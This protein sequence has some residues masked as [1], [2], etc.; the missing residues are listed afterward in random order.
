MKRWSGDGQSDNDADSTT[1]VEPRAAD[2]GLGDAVA[3]L[4]EDDLTAAYD[5]STKLGADFTRLWGAV[6]VSAVG[7]GV[8]ETALPLLATIL[9]RNPV[10]VAGVLFASKLPWLLCSLPAGAIA[11]RVDRRRLVVLVNV[12]RAV[13]MSLLFAV[14]LGGGGALWLVY[15]VAFLQGV[16][17]VFSD[18]TAF[19]M[20]PALVPRAGLEKANGRLEAAAVM[21]QGFIGPTLGGVL[22]SVATAIPFGLD[23]SSFVIAAVLFMMIT[24]RAPRPERVPA[25]LGADIKEGLAWLK[26]HVLL[27]NLSVFAA[28]TNFVLHATFGI[29]V[30]YATG[31]LGLEPAGFGLLLSVEAVGVLCGSLLA[32]GIKR[33]IGIG[34]TILVSLLIAG[35]ANF[36][37]G[38]SAH[39]VVVGAMMVSISFC[40]GVWN[41]VTNSLRQ[42]TVP[43]RL[44]GRVQ[45]AHRLLSWGA[46][47]VGTIF[48]GAIADAF[49]L[50]A[51]FFVAAAA[52][53]VLA[54]AAYALVAKVGPEAG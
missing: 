21:G 32:G 34:P 24:Y 10:L 44:M 48:G 36:V 9:T 26:G 38:A 31:I 25:T 43:D 22:F 1:M 20:T 11:D 7:D 5:G 8:R 47:P 45:S 28:L 33:Q 23:A 40:A 39:V 4:S 37:I 53:L 18:N 49:G 30:L 6:A 51:P 27:R 41:V 42:A 46:I 19:A 12:L 35:V 16:G 2:A 17:E 50:R 15:A 3:R 29:F 52:L 54:V 13:T 14:V